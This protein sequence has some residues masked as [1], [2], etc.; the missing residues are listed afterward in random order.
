M[1]FYTVGEMTRR[2]L[3]KGGNAAYKPYAY[4]YQLYTGGWQR[5]RDALERDWRP[6]LDGQ[7]SWDDALAA[8]VRD[9]VS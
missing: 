7:T 3:G 4:R 8:L 6:Y 1:I 9:A 5:L 2:E